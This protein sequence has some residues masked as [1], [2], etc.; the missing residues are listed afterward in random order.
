MKIG[1]IVTDDGPKTVVYSGKKYYDL[2]EIVGEDLE[3]SGSSFFF[4]VGKHLDRINKLLSEGKLDSLGEVFP[5]SFLVPVPYV[6]QIRDFYAFEE[7]VR[8]ARR[9]R[10]LDIASEWYDFPVYYYSGTSAL[11]PSDAD[12]PYPR[13][14]SELDFEVELAAVI[15]KEGKNI[16]KSSAWDH[17]FGF[18]LMNDWSA[19]DQ[20]KKEM[21]I[22]LG[23]SKSKDFATSFGR[24]IVTADEAAGLLDEGTRIDSE[25]WVTVNDREYMRN[26]L[27][28]MH[29]SFQELISWASTEVVLK[30]GDI[31][32]SGTI[33]KGCI[34]ELGQDVPG[35]LK[36]GDRVSFGSTDFG[37]LN[38]RIV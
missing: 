8:N 34:L 5:K 35:Y 29:W 16:S 38:S 6:N 31:L 18:V 12:V 9:L 30:P 13:F 15:G 27:K 21:A 11:Y 36:S 25:V 26:N 32:M 20:Q 19:R 17:I 24:F 2:S 7:H 23:P 14:S 28:T 10:N 37:E 1:R 22:G 33:G 3:L 4:S